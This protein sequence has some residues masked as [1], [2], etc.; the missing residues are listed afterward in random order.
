M[1]MGSA[2]QRSWTKPQAHSHVWV[3]FVIV[4]TYWL[5]TKQFSLILKHLSQIERVGVEVFMGELV[6]TP[7]I[8]KRTRT[9]GS[10]HGS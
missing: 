10:L 8:I 7:N 9:Q 1:R 4:I 2:V 6:Y 3:I 5:P